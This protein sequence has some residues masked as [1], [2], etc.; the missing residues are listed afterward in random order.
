MI[1]FFISFIFFIL[2]LIPFAF[3]YKNSLKEFAT[4]DINFE[5]VRD[6]RYFAKSF[7]NKFENGLNN[8]LENNIIK[9]SKKEKLAI[10]SENMNYKKNYYELIYIDSNDLIV[11]KPSN[12]YKE[13]YS[14]NSIYFTKE[15]IIRAAYSEKSITLNQDSRV[16]RWLDAKNKVIIGNNCFLGT[17][18]SSENFLTIGNSCIF[19]R[20]YAPKIIIGKTND[21][22]SPS[23]LKISPMIFKSI[24]RNIKIINDQN[25]KG[26]TFESSI[27]TKHSLTISSNIIIK[28]SI[29]TEKDLIIKSNVLIHGN[30]FADGN[31]II[32]NNCKILGTIFSY[33]SIT[34]RDF[35][36]IGQQGKIKSIVAEENITLGYNFTMH[37]FISANK[38]GKTI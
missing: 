14:N 2:M 20:L 8:N 32:G 3:A 31:I 24:K 5:N 28:G 10:L 25:T 16:I 38:I 30:I 22:K 26:Y 7:K 36:Q 18:I 6:P 29:K 12:F 33:N 35:V 15:H 37:G 13:I 27:M 4:L 17:S 9:L 21:Y 19:K 11:N 23:N 1:I 34:I